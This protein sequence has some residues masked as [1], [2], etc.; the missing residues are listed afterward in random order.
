MELN[1]NKLMEKYIIKSRIYLTKKQNLKLYYGYCK[2]SN[3]DVFIKQFNIEKEK[4]KLFCEKTLNFYK[5][6]PDNLDFILYPEEIFYDKNFCFVIYP[7]YKYDLYEFI[8]K[9]PLN[10]GEKITIIKNISKGI[11]KLQEYQIAHLDLKLENILIDQNLNIKI[12]DY[13][14]YHKLYEKNCKLT[15]VVGTRTVNAP[16]I[17]KLE[18]N[19]KSDIW[20]IGIILL[21]MVTFRDL[22]INAQSTNLIQKYINKTIKDEEIRKILNNILIIEPE[23]RINIKKLNNLFI[24]NVYN[25]VY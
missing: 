6:I 18:Y 2:R 10:N 1:L 17:S 15:S 11:E 24:K 9:V 3:K 13:D 4:N 8:N 23:N 19:E 5:L 7:Y 20:S 22:P 25:N 21:N 12:I 14:T 16:E